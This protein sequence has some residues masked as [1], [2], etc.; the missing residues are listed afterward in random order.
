MSQEVML[1]Y[2]KRPKTLVRNI[3]MLVFFTV[4]IIWSTD[5]MQF[6]GINPNGIVI[7][8]SILDALTK[9]NLE[10]LFNFGVGTSIPNLM[11]E[12]VAIAFLGTILGA[13]LAVPFAFIS[14]RNI[15]GRIASFLGNT[16]IGMI[17]TFPIFILGLMFI[18][19]TGPGPLAGVLTIG[20]SSIGMISKLY[21]EIIE[22]IDNGIIM[23]LDATGANAIQRIRYG[24]IPQLTPNFISTAIYR[25]EINVRNATILSLVGEGG[26]GFT[27]TAALAVYRWT[28]AAAALW[29]IVIV[30]LFIEFV[31]NKIRNS[32][33]SGNQ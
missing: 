32:L 14:A 10:W 29:G 15:T 3:I 18:R 30:V 1:M 19:V 16:V 4:V 25:F 5:T 13:I 7:S 31:S 23:A 11:L 33:V 24:I 26:I 17:R 20:I 22:D 28:D 2:E 8:R 9:P 6:S 21:V 27:L 12:T